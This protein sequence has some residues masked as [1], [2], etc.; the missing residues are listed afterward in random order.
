MIT[1]NTRHQ[2]VKYRTEFQIMSQR[3]STIDWKRFHKIAKALE[4]YEIKKQQRVN[5][6]TKALEVQSEKN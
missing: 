5:R 1:I 3:P 2:Y 4:E 6:A